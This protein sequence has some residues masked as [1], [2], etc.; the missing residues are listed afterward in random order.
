VSAQVVANSIEE[1]IKKVS[2]IREEWYAGEPLLPWC[3]GQERS[4]WALLPKL[5]RGTPDDLRTEFEIREEFATRA[6][7]LSDYAKPS[8]NRTLNNW[9][10]YFVMQHY[11]AATRLLDWTDASL[12]ALYFA[13]RS[14]A[15]NFP[16]AV[17]I[18]DAWWLNREVIK[19]DEVIPPADPGTLP[20]D[21]KKVAPWLPDR[22]K[23]GS[24][25]PISP[26]AVFPTHT[27]RR[28]SAQRS[29]FTIHGREQYGFEKL[30]K[31]RARLVKVEIPSWE[32][33]QMRRSLEACGIDEVSIFPDMEALGRAVTLTW[34]TEKESLPH[35]GVYTRLRKS[36]THGIGV[37]AI[38]KIRRGT[39]LFG[40]DDE[41]MVWIDEG[42]TN[43]L[44]REVKKLYSD[45]A[46][47]KTGRYGCPHSFN[48]LTPSWYINNSR[49]SPNVCCDE[50][51]EFFALRD[52]EP[53]EELT[54]DY[55]Q[56]SENEASGQQTKRSSVRDK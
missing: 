49:L 23:K 26:V 33:R 15:G 8:D 39:K 12:I 14:N 45:F 43:R 37:F 32:V 27:M 21:R 55:L 19:R 44:S 10:W 56:Y 51:Y 42:A 46:V 35:D 4:E 41:G 53:G 36:N 11:G 1:F 25:L 22:F 20:S 47:L 5:Y 17:W 24:R 18:L 9:E 6:P 54:V 16:A 3:R 52:I 2:E 29:C 48:R 34:K 50:T 31:K 7:A 30:D 38:R 13:V 28:I 40:S